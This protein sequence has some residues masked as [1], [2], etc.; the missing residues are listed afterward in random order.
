MTIFLRVPKQRQIDLQSPRPFVLANG[1]GLGITFFAALLFWQSALSLA[2]SSSVVSWGR[3]VIPAPNE[4]APLMD[5]SAGQQFNL[6][7]RPDGTVVAWGGNHYREA[8]VPEALTEVTAIAAG[9]RHGVALRRDG[10]VV[11]WGDN[12]MGQAAPPADLETATAISAG[13]EHS[14]A[15]HSDHTVSAWGGDRHG[16]ADPPSDLPPVAA[17]SAGHFH[18]LALLRDGTVVGWGLDD[19]GQASVPEGLDDVVAVAAGGFHSLALRADGTLVAWGNNDFGQ[20]SPPS[21]LKGI[22]RIQAG[23]DHSMI[24]LENG[25]T[26]VWGR[27]HYRQTTRPATLFD[28]RRI[29]AGHHHNVVLR[30][31]GTVAAW[32]NNSSGQALNPDDLKE[33]V[34]ISAWENH[35]VALKRDGS[36]FWWGANW[37]DG[38]APDQAR[39]QN[40]IAVAAGRAHGLALREDGSVVGWGDNL[41]GQ[42]S[43]PRDLVGAVAIASG[44]FHSLALRSDGKVYAWGNNFQEQASVPDELAQV[45]AIAGGQEHSVALTHDGQA[46]A[47]GNNFYEQCEVPPGLGHGISIAS[48][49]YHNVFL[50]GN[51]TMAAWGSNFFNQTSIPRGLSN[52]IA[53]DASRSHTV[54]IRED[55]TA[56]SWGGNHYGQST[57]PENLDQIIDA[58]AGGARTVVVTGELQ[59]PRI[60][61]NFEAMSSPAGEDVF[62]MPLI[63]GS[64]PFLYQWTK[65]G[66]PI[67]GADGPALSLSDVSAADSGTYALILANPAGNISSRSFPIEVMDPAVTVAA[68]PTVAEVGESAAFTATARGTGAF[69]YQWFKDGEPIPGATEENFIIEAVET[70]HT[71]IYTVEVSNETDSATSDPVTFLI[72]PKI[73]SQPPGVAAARV[74]ERMSLQMVV[75]GSPPLEF[76]WFYEGEPIRGATGST[77]VLEN[78]DV[79]NSGVYYAIAS[80]AVGR[81]ESEEILLEIVPHLR[82][83]PE[84]QVFS[85][86]GGTAVFEVRASGTP[87]LSYHWHKDGRPFSET[88]DPRLVIEG[89]R[90]DDAGE[91]HVV[92]ANAVGRV[93]SESATLM[94]PPEIVEHPQS[95]T[96]R[97]GH[98]IELRVQVRG[99]RPLEYQWLKD[100]VPIPEAKE[101]TLPLENIDG[102]ETARYSV[103]VSNPVGAV[104]S[105]SATVSLSPNITRQPIG[106]SFTED[107]LVTLEVEAEGSPPLFY[108]W[109]K[110][111]APIAD[112]NTSTLT[113]ADAASEDSG[114]YSVIVS[115]TAGI[116]ISNT[117]EIQMNSESP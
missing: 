53:T 66:Q 75:S 74:G 24:L 27:N 16:Q 103:I 9:S 60:F 52:V 49:A 83:Q 110:D 2:A 29:A 47:W 112:A 69:T 19:D 58:A 109:T 55:R 106:S 82:L 98:P 85:S 72:E 41:Y 39:L 18:N 80:N 26:W 14:I 114:R 61:S 12:R 1:V 21:Q 77:L 31:D 101:S 17:V 94:A 116:S 63:T 100:E 15:L 97:A 108:Q 81:V 84:P 45:I 43:P 105:Q 104:T 37:A 107:D 113:I 86:F 13:R 95:Q 30:N 51:G 6:G 34:S 89:V 115:N 28:G 46:F 40:V 25:E 44:E 20:A 65:D 7:L 92:V 78:V 32:G 36:V 73:Q 99:G 11:A 54:A 67:P 57:V 59:R 5:V 4:L 91:Y 68:A 8:T 87:P 62:I 56:V 38:V 70:A 93:E 23:E 71:G 117:V 76:Q 64:R 33:T 35:T 48:G 10:A 42:A 88:R 50:H 111:G 3:Q 79:E 96:V 22:I 90:A 102:A